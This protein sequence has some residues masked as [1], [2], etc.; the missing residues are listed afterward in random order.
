MVVEVATPVYVDSK[1]V[2][3][4]FSDNLGFNP[5]DKN[6]A[7]S[8]KKGGKF[9]D[10][11]KQNNIFVYNGNPR[12]KI[13]S[14]SHTDRLT[15]AMNANNSNGSDVYFYVNGA[16]K[17][18]EINQ[19]TCCF[20]DMDAGRDNEGK[21]FKPSVVVQHKKRFLDKINNFP[22]KPSWVIDTRNG[23][24]CYWI[25]D[26]HSRQLVGKNKTYWNG[27]QKKLVNYFGG[28]PRAI[29][30]NQIYR[31][32]YTWWRKG[33]EGK[34]PYFTSI[35]PGSTGQPINVADLQSALT[36]Q[37]TNIVIDPTKCSDE[38]YKGYA[39]AYQIADANNL[40]VSISVAKDILEQLTNKDCGQ[41]NTTTTMSYND[42]LDIT[43]ASDSIDTNYQK[44][45]GDPE[46]VQPVSRGGDCLNLSGQQT[47]LLKT[48]V[49][50]L[51]Q[52][53][54]ALYFSNNR[55]LS[56]A[57]KDLAAQLGDQFCIG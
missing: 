9:L 32:P 52:A 42:N 15:E 56:S 2:K 19:F 34:A 26:D 45:Y 13:S 44:T 11:F 21:Y 12:K 39:K 37:S 5:F 8:I 27:L 41:K 38:W 24:Q 22:V 20:C 48:V 1:Q 28:D 16:R 47:K 7:T 33:W 18:F 25:F 57:A 3:K 29:K 31:V 10:S 51:N 36:G 40:P 54:T 17:L 4:M 30:A 53:S 49:E 55:F 6:N 43:I 46:M 23:Y 14:M 35:L 50:Y